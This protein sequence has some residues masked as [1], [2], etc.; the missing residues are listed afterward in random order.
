MS[1]QKAECDGS[2][3]KRRGNVTAKDCDIQRVTASGDIGC[4]HL[5]M[6]TQLFV[7][8]K[9]VNGKAKGGQQQ[10][11]KAYIAT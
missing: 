6:M 7:M 2:D 5:F 3:I 10:Y 1:R 9:T 11:K 8:Q 4:K